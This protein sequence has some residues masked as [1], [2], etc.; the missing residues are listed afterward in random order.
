MF[1]AGELKSFERAIGEVRSAM[2]EAPVYP[3]VALHMS[4]E[5][6]REL[7]E[8]YLAGIRQLAPDASRVTDK[9]PAN[10]VFAGLIHLA[11]PN[12]RHHSYRPRSDGYLPLLFFQT[13]HGR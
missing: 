1:G 5:H 8:R 11:L 4:G 9:M 10:F 6:F 7:G 13:F 3:E 2:R 12:A